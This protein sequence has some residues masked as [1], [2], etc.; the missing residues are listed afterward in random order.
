M[1]ASVGFSRQ[2]ILSMRTSMLQKSAALRE[3]QSIE[4]T[5]PLQS[6]NGAF[7]KILNNLS[8]NVNRTA[9]QADAVT[10]AYEIGENSNIAEVLVARQKAAVAFEATLQT[11]NKLVTAYR[12]IMNMPV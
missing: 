4:G 11:R 5:S 1:V 12:D 10:Q 2:D 8:E 3:A 7:Q 9:Q 6:E